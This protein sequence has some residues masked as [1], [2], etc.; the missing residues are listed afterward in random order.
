MAKKG[1]KRTKRWWRK[2]DVHNRERERE[3]EQRHIFKIWEKQ[4]QKLH[5]LKGSWHKIWKDDINNN[6]NFLMKSP[7]LKLQTKKTNI[8]SNL[9]RRILDF[10]ILSLFLCVINEFLVVDYLHK[11]FVQYSWLTS[12][13]VGRNFDFLMITI[14]CHSPFQFL[15][16]NR[17]YATF[18][19]VL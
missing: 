4:K 17:F 13:T 7:K 12:S 3:R 10:K 16:S 14:F 18:L 6:V 9:K 11:W 5:H 8:N 19:L 2:T 1:E 15:G